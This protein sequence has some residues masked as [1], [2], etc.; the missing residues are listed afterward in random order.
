MVLTSVD[1]RFFEGADH[2]MST[3]E[4]KKMFARIKD[5]EQVTRAEIASLETEL[6]KYKEKVE[7]HFLGAEMARLEMELTKYKEKV[8]SDMLMI[9]L[10]HGGSLLGPHMAYIGGKVHNMGDVDPDHLTLIDIVSAL[11]KLGCKD[12]SNL[13]C[14]LD[15][16]DICRLS[17]DADIKKMLG[18][19]MKEPKNVLHVYAEHGVDEQYKLTKEYVEAILKWNPGSSAFLKKEGSFFQ[20]MYV[21]LDA[22]KKGLLAGCRPIISVGACFLKGAC[23]DI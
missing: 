14:K 7:N 23:G 15:E 22:C 11:T 17:K 20:R 10:Y 3:S 2:E 19:I 21:C 13:Y 5:I 9:L 6:T 18:K 16:E 12:T 1:C 8:D 4:E